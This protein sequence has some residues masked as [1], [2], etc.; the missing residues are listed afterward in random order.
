MEVLIPIRM[1][2]VT[3]NDRAPMLYLPKEARRLLGLDVGI[4]VVIYVDVE[5][6]ALVVKKVERLPEE[7]KP[8]G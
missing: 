1:T 3:T 6:R 5:N 4:P 7:V 2:K 8:N